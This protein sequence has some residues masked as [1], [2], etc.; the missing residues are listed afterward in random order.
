MVARFLGT[1]WMGGSLIRQFAVLSLIVTCLTTAALVTLTFYYVRK[2]LLAWEWSLT[3]DYIGKE[4]RAYLTPADFASP[5]SPTAQRHF[6]QLYQQTILMPGIV[7][8][9]IYDPTMAVVWS[10]EPRLIGQRFPSNLQLAGALA[11]RTMVNLETGEKEGENVYEHDDFP[12]LVE[13]YVPIVFAGASGVAG[14]IETYKSPDQVFANIRRAQV[15]V[16]TT[17]LAGA[18]LIYCS[19][20]WVVRRASQRIEHQHQTLE[21]QTAE[22]TVANQEL[23]NV[24]AQLLQ[25]ERMAAIGAVVTAV[26]HGIRNPLANIRA[27]AQV[28]LLD[29]R[30]SGG[31]PLMVKTLVSVMSEVD[32]LGGRVTDLLQF[33]R[34]A[35]RQSKPL[36][37]NTVIRS[38]LRM[39]AGR[40]AAANIK[41]VDQLAPALP[42]IMGDPILLEQVFL[43]LISNAIEA[44]ANSGTLTLRSGITDDGAEVFAE[45]RDTGGGISPDEISKIFELFYTTKPQ[46]TGLGLALAKKFVEAHEGSITVASEPGAGARFR[47]AFPIKPP[48]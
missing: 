39:T 37:L 23:R 13:V 43:G 25:A 30:E 3:S 11:G 29:C 17:A 38:S 19:L 7:R 27:A 34:P 26:A 24:Q 15:N 28:A 8:V 16:A 31:P 36:D 20:F 9:K 40:I 42:V 1:R 48:A 45:V 5:A 21:Q 14:V 18:A 47:V 10:D 32:R 33:V 2:D 41:V 44:V 4:A 46:G 22:L 35:E 12:R 6:Q